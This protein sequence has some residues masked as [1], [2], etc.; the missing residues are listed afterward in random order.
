MTQI[1][2]KKKL[3]AVGYIRVS[4]KDQVE[5]FSLDFQTEAIHKHCQG[6]YDLKEIY[7][8][9]GISGKTVSRRDSFQKMVAD[10]YA[11]NF[12]VVIVWK[13][14]RFSRD[15]ETGVASFFGLK[16]QGIKIVSLHE[17][18]TSDSDD[19][20]IYFTNGYIAKCMN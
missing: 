14:D 1:T 3:R 4:S 7:T 16:N 5:G 20:M 18:L 2:S 8:E 15:I 12:D 9:A 11:G 13:F 17:G 6:K 19:I 10:G